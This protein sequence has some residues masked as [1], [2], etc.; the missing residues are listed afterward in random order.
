MASLSSH[1]QQRQVTL[2]S[3][4]IDLA[5]D[6]LR[7][8]TGDQ[9]TLRPRSMAV[10]RL[11]AENAGRLV[12]KDELIAEVWGDVIVTDDSLTQCVADIRKVIG[13]EDHRVLRTV[14]RRGYMLVPAQRVSPTRVTDRPVIAVMPFTSLSGEKE[15]SLAVGVASEI[16]NE[17]AR[18]RDLKVIGRESSFAV[19]GQGVPAQELGERLGARYLVEGTVQRSKNTLVVD[20][21]LVSARDGIIAWGDRFSATAADIP[22]MRHM[23]AERIAASLRVSVRETEKRGVLGRAPRDLSV[24]E[25]TLC[26][27]SKHRFEPEATRAS[28]QDYEEALRRDP[29]YA[30]AWA[31]LAWTNMIDIW[32]ELTGEW[33]L[34]RIDEVID[35]FQRAI[36]LDPNLAKPY[37]GLSQALITKGDVAY[38]L[39]L[40]KRAVELA[41]SEPDSLLFHGAALFESGDVAAAAEM[42]DK[43]MELHP[44][45]PSY[46]HL[47]GTK[48]LW[49]N[50]RFQE[51]LDEANE[52]LRKAPK[53]RSAEIYRMLALVNLG[54]V[55]E[56]Q[57]QLAQTLLRCSGPPSP[58]HPPELASRYLADLKVAGWRPSLAAD[59]E[60]G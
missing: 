32:G 53:L 21:Q 40:S 16:L 4:V 15:H 52:C 39:E 45:P 50:R 23:I 47:Y 31:L 18:N 13:D 58:P 34:S 35:Q 17:L 27:A 14:P 11:L 3:H 8:S 1:M 60:A 36:E 29:N 9:I 33:D 51:A 20:L 59:R 56:A 7:S 48:I 22:L 10:L 26:G 5:A 2:P 24:Y 46:Y 25:L 30:P 54:R 6:E 57:T 41:P 44:V 38:A 28:R 37:F 12:L 49:G 55:A 19:S 43:A 42:I